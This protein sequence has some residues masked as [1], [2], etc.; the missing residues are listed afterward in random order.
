MDELVKNERLGDLYAYYGGLLTKRQQ[1]YFED[2]YYDDLSLG[3][4]AANH[5]V[6][7]QAVYD[8]LHRSGQALLRYEKIVGMQAAF[9]SIKAQ[10]EQARNSSAT[11]SIIQSL[12]QQV[13]GDIPFKNIEEQ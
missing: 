2:Y 12:L 13:N 8:N 5:Q 10:L 9:A 1:D 4:I 11:D 3:E 6:S 7:R